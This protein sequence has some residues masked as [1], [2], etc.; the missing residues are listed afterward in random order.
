MMTPEDER[1][2]AAHCRQFQA[3]KGVGRQRGCDGCEAG[4]AEC[5]G[6]YCATTLAEKAGLHPHWNPGRWERKQR[7]HNDR[8]QQLL[9]EV[10]P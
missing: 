9:T 8:F 7:V 10:V 4:E 6:H 2:I 3:L 1:G 5:W